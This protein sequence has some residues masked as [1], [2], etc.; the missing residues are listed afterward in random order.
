MLTFKLII[1]RG[2]CAIIKSQRLIAKATFN[3]GNLAALSQEIDS[4]LQKHGE[5]IA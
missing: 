4:K 2:L 5:Q 3:K 1:L